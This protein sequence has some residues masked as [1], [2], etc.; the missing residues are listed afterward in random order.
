MWEE[1]LASDRTHEVWRLAVTAGKGAR[2]CDNWILVLGPR[3]GH[4]LGQGSYWP[5]AAE[6]GERQEGDACGRTG[7]PAKRGH[8]VGGCWTQ[9]CMLGDPRA[10]KPR[11]SPIME[12]AWGSAAAGPWAAG[13]GDEE[14]SG[15]KQLPRQGLGPWLMVDEQQEV[16]EL[17]GS[18]LG[19][20]SWW[21]CLR[22]LGSCP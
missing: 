8:R 13:A 7:H 6:Q 2:V 3:G 16:S 5:P 15:R 19:S 11:G 20:G 12:G 22:P 1:Q 21:V 17:P 18:Q 14:V 9:L 10:S 4:W